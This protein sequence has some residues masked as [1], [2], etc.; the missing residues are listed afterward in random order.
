MPCAAALAR[1]DRA[2]AG[3]FAD[4]VQC[5]PLP[6]QL[7]RT[8]RRS[9]NSSKC[10]RLPDKREC[11]SVARQTGMPSLKP[12]RFGSRNLLPLLA[13]TGC[14][15]LGQMLVPQ[16]GCENPNNLEKCVQDFRYAVPAPAAPT[17]SSCEERK[18]RSSPCRE[19]ARLSASDLIRVRNLTERVRTQIWFKPGNS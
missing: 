2:E 14:D 17:Q 13:V 18:I 1:S 8:R 19:F 3:G 5:Q 6:L 16:A 10:D 7:F 12:R 9:F 4:L 15:L 11:R